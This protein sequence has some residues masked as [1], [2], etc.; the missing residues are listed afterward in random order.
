MRVSCTRIYLERL[1]FSA[2]MPKAKNQRITDKFD[3]REYGFPK[4]ERNASNFFF[5]SFHENQ[6]LLGGQKCFIF[7]YF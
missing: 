3:R 6:R 2:M 7:K 5:A 1:I 4:D